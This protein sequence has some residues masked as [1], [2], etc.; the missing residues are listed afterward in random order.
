ML[1]L[2]LAIMPF[3][4]VA[5]KEQNIFDISID[6]GEATKIVY[7]TQI[8]TY[9][10]TSY[11]SY[12][13]KADAVD[14]EA[15]NKK[16]F[17]DLHNKYR[18]MHG[19]KKLLWSDALFMQCK[20]FLTNEYAICDGKVHHSTKYKNGDIG[21]IVTIGFKTI[22]EFMENVYDTKYAFDFDTGTDL[23]P[24]TSK[25]FKQLV[26][27]STSEFACAMSN[28]GEY[29]SSHIICQYDTGIDENTISENVFPSS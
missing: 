5:L 26:W 7:Q 12:T 20:K 18:A 4:S 2:V 8:Y 21:E 28:C 23:D 13:E 24:A 14:N 29:F 25:F 19:A 9:T 17:V 16:V 11:A 6:N 22:E 27:N 1:L 10:K 3:I 15:E